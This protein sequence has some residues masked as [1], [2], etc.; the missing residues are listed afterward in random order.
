MFGVVH[1]MLSAGPRD[2][3]GTSIQP[4]FFLILGRLR[5]MEP[6]SIPAASTGFNPADFESF[7]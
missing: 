5:F 6:G 1:G 3:R 7:S 2:K 4:E